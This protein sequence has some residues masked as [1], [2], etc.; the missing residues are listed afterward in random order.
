MPKSDKKKKSKKKEK[1]KGS[2]KKKEKS[3]G[4]FVWLVGYA[5]MSWS[6]EGSGAECVQC[7]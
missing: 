2:K 4:N 7:A 3:E 5:K 6:R 1:D